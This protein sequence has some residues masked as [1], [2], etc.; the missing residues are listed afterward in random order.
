M[1]W[2]SPELDK[3]AA[4]N[5]GYTMAELMSAVFAV[6]PA[7]WGPWRLDPKG[8]VL[9]VDESY[10]WFYEIDLDACRTSAAVANWIFQVAGKTWAA[11]AV[12]S[13]LVHAL[14]D[15]LRPQS[16]LCS[17]GRDREGLLALDT[18]AL[19]AERAAQ[20]GAPQ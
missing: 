16:T 12:V 11:A 8:R 10:G 6:D 17:G 3:I 9:Y 19:M 7:S 13:G 18:I 4:R 5:G 2:T 15:V 20:Y 14:A 1:T